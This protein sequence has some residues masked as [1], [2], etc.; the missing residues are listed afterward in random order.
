[1]MAA[2]PLRRFAASRARVSSAARGSN[3]IY[4][5]SATEPLW[6]YARDVCDV[7]PRS[8]EAAE[9][10]GLDGPKKMVKGIR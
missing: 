3:H 7:R 9:R 10:C 5:G 1:M 6:R 2:P 8:C 4:F